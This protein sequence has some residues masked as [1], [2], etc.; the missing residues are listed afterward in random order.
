MTHDTVLLDQLRQESFQESFQERLRESFPASF[1]SSF[2]ESLPEIE[3]PH[4]PPTAAVTD[5]P[6]DV[7]PR[8]PM[9][10]IKMIIGDWSVDEFGN[11]CREIRARD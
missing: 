4:A 10:G 1:Q 9:P 2:Q 3:L 5:A 8:D 6:M 11:R 7:A